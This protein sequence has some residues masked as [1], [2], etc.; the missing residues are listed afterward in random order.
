MEPDLNQEI[1]YLPECL[2][3]IPSALLNESATLFRRKY[4]LNG[5]HTDFNMNDTVHNQENVT[6]IR[7]P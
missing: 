7:Q 6:N 5:N 3:A 2:Y 1:Y 4:Y